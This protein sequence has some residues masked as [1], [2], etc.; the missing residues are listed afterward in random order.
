[1]DL[2][3]LSRPN[4]GLHQF[5]LNALLRAVRKITHVQSW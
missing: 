1:M 3:A 2:Q 5:I 4:P